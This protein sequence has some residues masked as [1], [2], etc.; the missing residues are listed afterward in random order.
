MSKILQDKVLEDANFVGATKLTRVK[1]EELSVL[2]TL[3]ASDL[4]CNNLDVAGSVTASG[5]TV[6]GGTSI[7]GSLMLKAP[8]DPIKFPNTFQ[9]LE[10]S[11]EV[12][13]LEDTDVGED[14]IVH[15]SLKNKAFKWFGKDRKQV[16]QLL[17]KTTVNGNVIFKSGVGVIEQ[18]SA[19]KITGQITGATVVRKSNE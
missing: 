1:A 17:G 5:I 15:P 4:I 19:A 18:D 2:G 13:S 7:V 9:N 6:K 11:A 10:I 3:E 14:I 8:A 16:L 12:I